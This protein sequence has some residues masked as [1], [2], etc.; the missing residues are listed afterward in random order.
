MAILGFATSVKAQF[1]NMDTQQMPYQEGTWSF[2]YGNSWR[3][4]ALGSTS[5]YGGLRQMR[6][7]GGFLSQFPIYSALF[8]SIDSIS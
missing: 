3:S 1:E 7:M 2:T 4:F 6:T 5:L 8:G